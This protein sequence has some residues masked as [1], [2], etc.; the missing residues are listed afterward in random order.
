M[1]PYTINTPQ[2]N[3]R[4]LT[5][6]DVSERYIRWLNDPSVNQFLETRHQEQTYESCHSFVNYCNTCPNEHLFGI[7]SGI[8]DLHI[9]NAKIGFIN[10]RYLKGELSLF[11]GD[12]KF[13][14]KGIGCE[15]VHALTAFGFRQLGL[16][17][18]EAGC[19]EE[20]IASLRTFLRIGYAIE[21][22]SRSSVVSNNRRCGIYRLGM[23]QAEFN[24]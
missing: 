6:N 10:Q 15:V 3:L 4:P 24:E 22:F 18:I 7:F 12:Q 2:V 21:G 20:N 14:G 19:Y 11:I 23:V 5:V 1:K 17:K 9:G 13:L 8:D 16:M